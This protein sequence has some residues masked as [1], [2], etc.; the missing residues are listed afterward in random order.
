VVEVTNKTGEDIDDAALSLSLE[1]DQ[2]I[3]EVSK[4]TLIGGEPSWTFDD[5]DDDSLYFTS[6]YGLDIDEDSY[7]TITLT[8]KVYF[9][10]DVAKATTF[11]P[12][13]EIIEQGH[14]TAAIASAT[15]LDMD[16]GDKR[17]TGTIVIKVTNDTE[18][19]ADLFA[20][21]L[22]FKA[23]E[24]IPVVST[25]TLTG[26]G[27]TWAFDGQD[28]DSLYF[29]SAFG[30]D[31]NKNNFRTMSLTLK[32][33]FE[34]DVTEDTHFEESRC[35]HHLLHRIGHRSREHPPFWNCRDKGHER[36]QQR[37]QQYRHVGI[38]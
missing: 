31:I 30:L 20:L 26:G 36:H 12:A 25:A 35:C 29:T 38:L 28:D 27:L 24:D 32:V 1:A 8:L 6:A 4:A 5:Q 3:P 34:E 14:L 21:L 7:K 9:Y 17:F 2:H 22:T 33:V 37:C 11:E 19:N 23:D 10:E 15:G 13:V 16:D 18:G